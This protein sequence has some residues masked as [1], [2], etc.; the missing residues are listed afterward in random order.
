V[1]YFEGELSFFHSATPEA[2]LKFTPLSTSLAR[3][4]TICLTGV[5]LWSFTAIFIGYLGRAYQLPAMVL[6]FWRDAFVGLALAAA[7]A[8]FAPRLL[9]P[10]RSHLRFLTLYGLALAI[11]NAL[12]TVSVMLNGAAISTVLVY[13][14]AGITALVGWRF[15]GEKL[16]APKLGAVA[17]SLA[18]MIFV[19]GAYDPAA[20][21]LNFWGVVTGLVSG[22][23]FATYSLM[24][25]TAAR[26][27]LPPWT[28]LL[29]VFS[30]AAVFLLLYNLIPRQLPGA[31]GPTGLFF[32]GE[33]WQGWLV[34]FVLAVGP[35]IGGY[36]L[37]TVSLAYLPASVANLLAT[38]E[39]VLTAI[40]AYLLLGERLTP[41]QLLGGALIFGGVLLLR[42][43]EG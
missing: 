29:Y 17:F 43:A 24:G 40:L 42:K 4:Y 13:S 25:R 11:F 41:L 21:R 39:P 38:L 20:W 3:G 12:W 27:G 6:A 36:G 14:S 1:V 15:L 7:F 28:T 34:L 8:I 33:A 5:V 22:F 10:G 30:I 18:G 9:N 31:D 2:S 32:L 23:G 26:R 37:Y 19:S 16:N 35:T